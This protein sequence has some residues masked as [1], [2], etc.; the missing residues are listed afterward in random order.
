MELGLFIM[1]LHPPEKSRTLCFEEDIEL[2][3]RADELGFTEA[4]VGQHHTVAWEPIPSNDVFIANVFPRTQNIRLGT[5]VSIVPQHHPAN[6]AVRLAFLDHL[7]R[8]R[9]NC[10]FGQG[11][12][13]TDWGLF[14]LPDPKT[15]GLMTVE[16]IDMVLKLWE[17]EA[18]FDFKGDFWHI[19]IEEPD[20]QHGIGTMLKPYQKPHPPIAMSVIRGESMAGRMAG[21]RGYI[22]IS[23]NL[24]PQTTLS[25]HWDT[26][27]AG[28]RQAALPEP[29]RARWRIGRSIFVGETDDEAW[30]YALDSAFSRAFDYLI[31]VLTGANMLHI[32]KHDPDLPDHELTPEYLV[33]NLCIIGSPSSC[34]EQLEAMW[35]RTGGF[36]TLLMIAHDWD[37]RAKWLRSLDLLSR[38]VKPALPSL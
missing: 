7:S 17:A 8:G 26:Y 24:V 31:T 5:G 1:P 13:P 29:S 28:A 18:P 22:P 20:H 14:D 32:L 12:V 3:V 33:R 30:E 38:Q 27:C 35:E 23:T 15:Q 37:D 9:L 10:G 21:Q 19:K 25:Q 34:I 11:G 6:I 2:V 4:W 16:G 36:G